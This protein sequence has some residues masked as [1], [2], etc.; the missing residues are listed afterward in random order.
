MVD[1]NS[2][3]ELRQAIEVFFFA[4]R[5]FT[6]PPDQI[7]AEQGLGRVH[8]RILYFVGRQP[9]LTV[10]ELLGV[11]AVSKQALNGPLR[12]LMEQGWVAS[13]Q[14]A[15]DRRVKR[16]TLTPAGLALEKRL[17]A[18]QMELLATAF[19]EAGASHTQAWRD[20]MERIAAQA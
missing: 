1:V 18:T 14:D 5:A 13:S 4:Y 15:Q 3:V 12:Q 7:L 17:S 16:L 11:L 19:A 10:S 6:A 20:L 9:G 2:E 8:H